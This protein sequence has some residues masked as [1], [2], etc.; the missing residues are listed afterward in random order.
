MNKIAVLVYGQY[1]EFEIAQKS[2][3]FLNEL[4]CDFYFSTWN[5]SCHAHWHQEIEYDY[6]DENSIKTFYPN[7]KI[8]ILNE[9]TYERIVHIQSK[10]NFYHPKKSDKMIFHWKNGLKLI[11]QSGKCYDQLILIRFDNFINFKLNP[12]ILYTCIE[13]VKIYNNRFGI[14]INERKDYTV[15]DLFFISKF[16]ILE[17]V[18]K[19]LDFEIGNLNIHDYLA[20]KIMELGYYVYPL[21]DNPNDFE[22]CV[23]RPN[24]KDLD[25]KDINIVTVNEKYKNW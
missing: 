22:I 15:D 14:F 5:R 9:E 25:E 4:N 16:S 8:S 24:V 6:I 7:S 1:R 13:D 11:E 17:N 20:K 2:W 12:E 10:Q 19:N 21:T 18:I 3:G 23:V